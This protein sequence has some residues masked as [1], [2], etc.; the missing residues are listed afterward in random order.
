M[1]KNDE[2]KGF[3]NTQPACSIDP[4]LIVDL[5]ASIIKIII[6]CNKKGYL[7]T[8]SENRARNPSLFDKLLLKRIIRKNIAPEYRNEMY[9]MVLEYGKFINE[10]TISEVLHE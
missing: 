3:I 10:K 1:L 7:G 9:N 6:D 2:L 4:K 8:M 5:L